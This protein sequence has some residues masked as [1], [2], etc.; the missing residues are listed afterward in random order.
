MDR[1][2]AESAHEASYV[3]GRGSRSRSAAV[4]NE[5]DAILTA[6]ERTNAVRRY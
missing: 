4:I 5:L 6:L 2:L 1:F 3:A